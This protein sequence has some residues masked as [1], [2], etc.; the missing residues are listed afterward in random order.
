MLYGFLAYLLWGLF[1]AYFPLLLPAAPV[2]IIAHRIIWT[3]VVMGIVITVT[4]NGANYA[5]HVYPR[6]HALRLRQYS[7][8]LTG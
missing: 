8:P 1:P 6:G 4:K 3:G 7:S 5:T 2:E